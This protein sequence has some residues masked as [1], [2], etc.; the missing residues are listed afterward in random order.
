MTRRNTQPIKYFLTE[1]GLKFNMKDPK[2]LPEE[3]EIID[4]LMDGRKSIST[5]TQ[6]V[7]ERLKINRTW[8]FIQARLEDLEKEEYVGIF[9]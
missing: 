9:K 2:F 7:N 1:K 3:K 4:M 5:I 8:N 6:L